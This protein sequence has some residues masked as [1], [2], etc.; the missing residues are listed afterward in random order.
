MVNGYQAKSL[1]EALRIR[2]EQQVVPYSGGTDVMLEEH[3][4]TTFL[5]LHQVEEMRRIFADAQYI[6]IGSSCTFTEILRSQI[7]PQVLKASIIE[8]AAPAIRNLGTI[9]GNICNGSPKADSALPLYVMDA[10]LRLASVHGER[11]IPI[12]DF[13]L[14][15]KKTALRDD[16]LLVE[17]LIPRKNYDNFYYQKIG[18]RKALAISRISFVGLFEVQEGKI[19]TCAIAFGAID[20]TILRNKEIERI[21]IGK[22]REEA[23]ILKTEFLNAYDRI[24]NPIQGR[25]SSSYR[26]AV[27]MNLIRDFLQTNGI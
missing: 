20:A 13:Y 2:N 18:A 5:F 6:R 11:V 25:V 22:T 21:F 4:D 26:K 27:C 23:T 19:T 15:R 8:I 24:I 7:P 14:G 16:E 3:L 10:Q 17:I 9:G 1:H 12:G